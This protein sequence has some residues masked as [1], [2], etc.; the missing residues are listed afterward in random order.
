MD[1]DNSKVYRKYDCNGFI[2]YCKVFYGGLYCA[3]ITTQEK[4]IERERITK[5]NTI[6]VIIG[7]IVFVLF[8][9]AIILFSSLKTI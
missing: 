3:N 9:G 2:D 7:V 8:I 1:G 5:K 6:I 4:A